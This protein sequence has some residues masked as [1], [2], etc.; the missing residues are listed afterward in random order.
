[1]AT[2]EFDSKYVNFLV[3]G[4]KIGLDNFV[5]EEWVK[6]CRFQY[7]FRIRASQTWWSRLC[8]YLWN[9]EK[10]K[11]PGP[12]EEFVEERRNWLASHYSATYTYWHD[13]VDNYVKKYVQLA[14][15]RRISEENVNAATATRLDDDEYSFLKR[16]AGADR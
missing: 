9:S 4:A 12:F 5:E 14:R 7:E 8:H 15:L 1:M 6:E 13:H 10:A 11:H 2:R 3:E 16:Y